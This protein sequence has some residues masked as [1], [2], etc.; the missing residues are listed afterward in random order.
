MSVNKSTSSPGS[1][2]E[3]N[4]QGPRK[5]K[6][7]AE[8]L[9]QAQTE[10]NSPEKKGNMDQQN[11][12][13]QENPDSEVESQ[14]LLRRPNVLK[15]T[16]SQTAQESAKS[17]FSQGL[18]E[19]RGSDL[20]QQF[21]R[22]MNLNPEVARQNQQ[23][24]Q[25]KDPGQQQSLTRES[26][27]E[28]LAR[29]EARRP[30]PQNPQPR[31]RSALLQ[32][33]VFQGPLKGTPTHQK[34]K[35]QFQNQ[36]QRQTGQRQAE[37]EGQKYLL[38]RGELGQLF[39]LR[40]KFQKKEEFKSYFK[41]EKARTQKSEKQKVQGIRYQTEGHQK[42]KEAAELQKAQQVK[43]NAFK[44]QMSQKLQMSASESKFE[45]VLQKVLAGQKSVPKLEEGLRARFAAK[46]EEQWNQFFQNALSLNS[47]EVKSQ[48]LFSKMIEALF[49]GLFQKSGSGQM[50]LVSD[51]AMSQDGDVVEHKYSQIPI[52]DAEVLELLK[53]LKPGDPISQ[54]LLK[55]LGEEFAYLKLAH[56]LEQMT[57]S[58]EEKK[59]V[60]KEFRQQFSKS[61]QNDL[62]RALARHRDQENKHKL[63]FEYARDDTTP[64]ERYIGPPKFFMYM[65]YAVGG[66]TLMIILYIL[67][68]IVL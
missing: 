46:T 31:V 11:P 38:K 57:V 39:R 13:L 51:L 12:L 60:L 42:Q 34:L 53:Q 35:S 21:G 44:D 47:A 24:T 41:Y 48:G 22:K 37:Q 14:S 66:V 30:M 40:H 67:F 1:S 9:K 61:A 50:M 45:Q 8:Q 28:G 36:Q 58:D 4:A 64:K 63:P 33:R 20:P 65:L 56:A 2:I 7:S 19:T 25:Q 17:R 68:R 55:K 29:F 3:S 43:N 5:T 10:K 16:K 27:K 62:E 54:D 23:T 6:P 15:E 52:E 49:R 26:G 32:D 59:R 18:K